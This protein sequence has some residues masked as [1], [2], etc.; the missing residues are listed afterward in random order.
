MAPF[1]YNGIDLEIADA[2]LFGDNLR[3]LVNADRSVPKPPFRIRSITL[4]SLFA[5]SQMGVKVAACCFIFIDV[6]IDPLVAH[7]V[8]AM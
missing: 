1:A 8:L 2:A 3:P 6:L 5:A 4:P 7:R